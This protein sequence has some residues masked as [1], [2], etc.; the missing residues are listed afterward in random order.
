MT[1][2]QTCALP[3]SEVSAGPR[4]H[5]KAEVADQRAGEN[6]LLQQPAVGRVRG[7]HQRE[8]VGRET[9]GRASGTKLGE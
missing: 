9:S 2:V 5:L 8:A 3:I 7:L 6:R 4:R 1:G